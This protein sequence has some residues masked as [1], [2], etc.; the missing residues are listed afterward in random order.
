MKARI[1]STV[2]L[3]LLL[4]GTLLN[5]GISGG[6][7]LLVICSALAQLEFYQLSEKIGWKPHKKSATLL[8]T[9]VLWGSFFS[10]EGMV[11]LN[12]VL[13][14]LALIFL[15]FA[16][17]LLLT[18]KPEDL[19]NIFIPTVFG[20]LYIPTMFCIP[21]L[22]IKKFLL[23]GESILA[24][25]LVLWIITVAKFSDIGGLLIGRRWGKHR[26]APL[27]S[28]AKTYEGL[29]GSLLFSVAVGYIFALCCS[30][31]WPSSFSKVKIAFLSVL[32]ALLALISDLIESGFKRLAKVKDSGHSIP[33][34]GGVLDLMDSLILSLPIG[35][36]VLKEFI[37]V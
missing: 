28:P 26:L 35:V 17:S 15:T 19:K 8:G 30:D 6:V 23:L 24:L 16:L 22:F 21:L 32:I 13:S 14:A 3:C 2:V 37:L 11:D 1:L 36:I 31:A 29:V 25:R 7:L 9:M 18:G 33:G 27:F 12:Y 20:I 34:I 10:R 5:G 4:I